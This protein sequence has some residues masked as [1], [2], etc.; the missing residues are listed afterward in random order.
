MATHRTPTALQ[1]A[2]PR[3]IDLISE[4]TLPPVTRA[5]ALLGGRAYTAVWPFI[6]REETTQ[7][8]ARELVLVRD[9]GQLIFNPTRPDPSGPP[10]PYADPALVAAHN[11]LPS[12]SLWSGAG[13]QR[14]IA[15]CRP[16]PADVYQRLVT[17]LTHFVDFT[18]SLAWP[19]WA[20]HAYVPQPDPTVPAAAEV[21]AAYILS[22]WFRP[23]LP[24]QG[25]LWITG[26]Q[27]SGKSRLLALL[28]RLAHLGIAFPGLPSTAA[29]LRLAGLGAAIAVDNAAFLGPARKTDAATV[30]RRS[31]LLTSRQS[32]AF[33]PALYH[34][35]GGGLVDVAGARLFA[36]TADP[37]STLAGSCLIIPLL[38]TADPRRAILDPAN[39]AA[40]PAG[41]DPAALTDD[42]WALALSR[43]PQLP[44]HLARVADDAASPD[45][46]LSPPDDRTIQGAPLQPWHALLAVASWLSEETRLP[47]DPDAPQLGFPWPDPAAYH[48]VVA[49]TTARARGA[50]GLYDRLLRLARAYHTE[51]PVLGRSDVTILAL[52]ALYALVSERVRNERREEEEADEYFRELE[53]QLAADTEAFD[54]DDPGEFDAAD[55]AAD[56]VANNSNSANDVDDVDASEDDEDVIKPYDYE[57]AIKD[58]DAWK[59]AGPDGVYVVDDVKM[60]VTSRAGAGPRPRGLHLYRRRS[61]QGHVRAGKRLQ[62]IPHTQR[63]QRQDRRPPPP[64]LAPR[65][66]PHRQ[67]AHLVRPPRRPPPP[68][69]RLQRAP[70]PPPRRSLHPLPRHRRQA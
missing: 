28:A 2:A 10:V 53:A 55:E 58:A 64:Q 51:R 37:D 15:G 36:T 4:S 50:P 46:R 14:Y 49:H 20:S 42:L 45:P 66:S 38:R 9:D 68:L 12:H 40:W 3:A 31:I 56:L 47:P 39:P 24:V 7:N 48:A 69:P 17:V 52:R 59:S 27:G 60:K 61:R 63:A 30:A 8:P 62:F 18:G 25:F 57:K 1:P 41:L 5:L 13:I 43:L 6:R 26:D 44:P 11:Y 54:S 22:T 70:P 65:L 32:G 23:A 21:L 16:D 35:P 29:L 19:G 34:S 33:W 67:I